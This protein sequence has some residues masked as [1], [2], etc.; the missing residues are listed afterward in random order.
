M[1]PTTTVIPK[2]GEEVTEAW[3]KQALDNDPSNEENSEFEVVRLKASD[4]QKGMFSTAFKAE[5]IERK[6]E[7][8]ANKI[9]LFIKTMPKAEQYAEWLNQSRQVV[10]KERRVLWG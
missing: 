8:K 5:A 3:L 4:E 10:T 2:N 1:S 6:K 9:G 7:A